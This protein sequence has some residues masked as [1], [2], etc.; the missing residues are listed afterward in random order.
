VL[1]QVMQL[2][3]MSVQGKHTGGLVTVLE[4]P[5]EQVEQDG[6]SYS[7]LH[8]VQTVVLEHSKH[9][10]IK[11]MHSVQIVTSFTYP[12]MQVSQL[13]PSYPISHVSQRRSV[14]PVAHT[15]Q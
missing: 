14:Q 6:P 15:V 1:S 8:L 7:I 12:R 5:L 9:W 10:S 3:L 13:T 2:I 11:L 4:Y